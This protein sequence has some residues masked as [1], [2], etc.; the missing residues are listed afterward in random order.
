MSEAV[1]CGV[2]DLSK[3]KLAAPIA[4]T[5]PAAQE[6]SLPCSNG[7]GLFLHSAAAASRT[8]CRYSSFKYWWQNASVL[9]VIP[10]NLRRIESGTRSDSSIRNSVWPAHLEWKEVPVDDL[11]KLKPV[12]SANPNKN[13]GPS[14]A[15]LQDSVCVESLFEALAL[16][17]IRHRNSGMNRMVSVCS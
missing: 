17:S 6:S 9:A 7:D 14:L 12:D 2:C 16:R 11:P 10:S 8:N 5:T 13:H 3:I 15:M 1:Q 4:W